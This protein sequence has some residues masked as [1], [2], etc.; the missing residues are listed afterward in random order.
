MTHLDADV[1]IVGAGV[2]GLAAARTLH[3]ARVNV[4]V[5]EARERL[6]GRI[7]TRRDPDL[8]LPIELGAEFIHGEAPELESLAEE[9]RLTAC[10]ASGSRWR[11]DRS[12]RSRRPALR[13]LENFW[14]QLDA[15]M[16]RLNAGRARDRSFQEFLDTR[17]GGRRL[18]GQRELALQWVEGF[19]AADPRRASARALADGGSP[20]DDHRERRLAR[21][22]D[23][24]DAV[25]RF[26][27]SGLE[28]RV[29]FGAVVSAVRW[30]S[31]GIEIIAGTS[32]REA[33]QTITARAAIISVPLGVLQA[34]PGD[35]GA[36]AF[37]PRLESDARK[38]EALSQMEMGSV[39]RVTLRLRERFW[40]AE[41]FVRRTGSQ[42]LDRLAFLHTGDPHFP[43]LWTV[44]PL[45]APVLVAWSGGPRARSLAAAGRPVTDVAIESMAAQFGLSEREAKRMVEA[46]WTH[47]WEHDPFSRGAYSYMTVGATDAPGKLARSLDGTLFFAGEASDA[48]GRTGTVH[49]AIASGRRAAKQALRALRA[50]GAS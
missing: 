7:F 13:P 39:V 23:G 25:P 6:G 29:R 4:V 27:G 31:G 21:F 10:D 2:A 44:Y 48:E 49:G 34:R 20:G 40:T 46:A 5:L 45:H 18:A 24:Y 28:D 12:R 15:V 30:R 43:V 47:D 42:D 35:P 3:E 50:L 22:V 16:S 19:H 33:S 8:S 11:A 41:R 17:P 1:A 26:L 36:I 32:E 14:E 38:R 37:E 9:A